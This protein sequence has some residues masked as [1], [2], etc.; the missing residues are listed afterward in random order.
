MKVEVEISDWALGMPV[1]VVAGKE[2]LAYTEPIVRH[3]GG[4]HVVEYGRLKVKVGRCNGCGQCCAGCVF[5][6]YDGCSFGEQTPIKC[7]VSDCS[8]GFDRCS[9][10]FV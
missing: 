2:L 3:E 10:E 4:E 1:Y 6:R 5:L 7:V 8:N 9:E